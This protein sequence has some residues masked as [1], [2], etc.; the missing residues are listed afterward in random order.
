MA[1]MEQPVRILYLE[2]NPTDAELVR[3]R[4]AAEGIACEIICV[5]TGT[6]YASALDQ[7]VWALIISDFTLPA[8]DGMSALAL[9]HTKR[10]D[11]PFIF[12]SGTVGEEAAI[13]ALKK[14][15][16]DYVLKPRP[17]RLV[18]AVKRAL[19]EA[20]DKAERKRAEEALRQSEARK[21]AFF[22]SALDCIITIDHNGLILEFNPAAEATFGY[23][24]GA[25]LGK[26]MA[27]LIIPPSLRE[28]HHRGM[29]RYLATG[30]GPV[31]GKRI[32]ITAMRADGTEFPVELSITPIGMGGVPTFTAS[33]RDISERKKAE[34]DKLLLEQQLRQAQKMEAIG[35]LTGGIAHDFNN[36]LTVILGYSEL[37]L[38]SLRSDDPMRSEV[39]QV[40]EAGVR[41][42]LL[43]RQLLA[44]SRKQVLD[45]KVLDLNAVLTNIDR[46][47][48][49]VIGE[50]IDLVTMPAPGLGRVKVDPGQ[51][52]QVIM[53]LAVNARDAM[54]QGG[55]LT[56]ETANVELD[57]AY[58]RKHVSVRPGSYVMLAVSDTGCGMDAETQARIFEPFFTTKE[59]GKG[60]GLGLST[61]YGIVKQSDGNIWVYSE[62][63]RGTTFK[64]Y[65]PIVEGAVET[66]EPSVAPAGAVRG[67]ETILLVE[68]DAGIRRLVRQVLAERGYWV[69]EAI[70]G[71]HAIQISEQHTV[72]IHLLVTDLVMPEMSGRDL[73]EHLKPSRPNMKVIFMSG[74]TDKAIVHRG[75][76]DP[77]TAFL[78]KPFTPDALAR[79]VREVLDAPAAGRKQVDA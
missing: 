32:E 48:Q 43:T 33:I 29:A 11:T 26:P 64:V 2:D 45:P 25:V 55:K 70:D 37:M 15:A 62:P 34:Q 56:I 30:E 51:I 27:E 60:T 68:D 44:F 13:D 6:D 52:E 17:A 65:L 73:A 10:P 12:F 66:V 36:M 59:V 39:E 75:E 18:S 5:Q 71:K 78:Q 23:A 20:Q 42:S 9:A 16:S 3:A 53:N 35:Q 50:D 58:A 54:P 79:K 41:A 31:L 40:Q 46:M 8:Y 76:L 4:L 28:K 74:Y 14:G 63:G 49:R 72:P 24:S 67:S 38:R 22:Q 57:N 61:V 47:L 19:Q 21:A 7:G 1:F 69:L 77:G